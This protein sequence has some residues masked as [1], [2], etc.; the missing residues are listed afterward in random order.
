VIILVDER[1]MVT[2]AYGTGFARE[3]ISSV[4]FEP[5]E[6]ED[7]VESA[8]EPDLMAVE[9]FVIGNCERQAAYPKIIRGRCPAPVLAMNENEGLDQ[10]LKLFEAGV[11]DVIRKP[12]HVRE[13]LAR[14]AAIVSR[15]GLEAVP[16]QVVGE[17]TVYFDGRDPEVSNQLLPLP[18]RERRI[19][20]YLAKNVGRRV[21]KTQLF[22]SVYG[23]FDEDVDESVIESHVSKL[24]KK[25]RAQL[26]HDPID[27]KRYLGY[28][29]TAS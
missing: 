29:L 7:W 13:I 23:I 26:G 19:L 9:A 6:F 10:T 18:R 28:C 16:H 20:E 14:I 11:D 3:G 12:V 21:T 17:L 5:P 24:R 8:P 27:S 1:E 25:L 22:N 15:G 4:G 2:S